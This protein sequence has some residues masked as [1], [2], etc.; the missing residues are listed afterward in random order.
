MFFL[1]ETS[2]IFT[3]LKK[4][5][6]QQYNDENISKSVESS[7]TLVDEN[8]FPRA[9]QNIILENIKKV[10][11]TR[12]VIRK[13][14]N[15][16]NTENSS[17][18][19]LPSVGGK[20]TDPTLCFEILEYGLRLF[21]SDDKSE[22]IFVGGDQK[23]MSLAFRLKKQHDFH[24]YYVTI[25]DLHFRKAL[26]HAILSQYEDLCL[27]HIAKL[28]SYNKDGQWEHLKNCSSIHKTFEFLERVCDSLRSALSFEFYM[29]LVE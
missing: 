13:L 7:G 6:K 23:T 28:C 14:Y 16:R 20:D 10:L 8:T 11:N 1:N 22:R 2:K 3:E 17:R 9:E 27:K 5:S 26:M 24:Q 21:G 19:I 12:D 29:H 4:L 15:I 18:I 25:L